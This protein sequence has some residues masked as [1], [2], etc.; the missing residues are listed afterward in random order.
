MNSKATF[1]QAAIIWTCLF[2]PTLAQITSDGTTGSIVNQNNS[3]FQIE[4]GVTRG[5]TLFHSFEKFSIPTNNQAYFTNPSGINLI[6]SRVTGKGISNI[7][8][9]LGVE[10]GADL[11]LMN[12]NGII[13]GPNASLDLNG[14]FLAT[15]GSSF[16]FEDGKTFSATNPTSVPNFKVSVPLGI[17]FGNVAA[18]IK[19]QARSGISYSPY[20]SY[21]ECDCG[22]SINSGNTISFLSGDFTSERGVINAP[23]G[24]IEIGSVDADSF[25]NLNPFTSGW[26]LG[27]SKV[28]SFKDISLS[29]GYIYNSNYSGKAGN[30]IRFYSRKQIIRDKALIK[31]FSY[32]NGI[33]GKVLINAAESVSISSGG[34]IISWS[35]DFLGSDQSIGGDIEINT[36]SLSISN[37]G[38]IF[39]DSVNQSTGGN[40]N[41]Q[42]KDLKLTNGGRIKTIALDSGSA[43]NI[44]IQVSDSTNISGKDGYFDTHFNNKIYVD[45]GISSTS[46][47]VGKTGN[48]SLSTKDIEISNGAGI[49]VL[50]LGNGPTGFLNIKGENLTLNN[51]AYISM[52]VTN[53]KLGNLNIDM[54][55]LL[56]MNNQSKITYEAEGL[57]IGGKASISAPMIVAFPNE[58]SDIILDAPMADTSINAKEVLGFTKNSKPTKMSDIVVNSEDDRELVG[59]YGRTSRLKV[60]EYREA[61]VQPQKIVKGCRPGQALGNGHFAYKGKGGLPPNPYQNRTM[62]AVWQDLR[63]HD[64]ESN[65]VNKYIKLSHQISKAIRD[66]NKHQTPRE[67]VV[68]KNIVAE[69][70]IIE[71]KGWIE[72]KKGQIILTSSPKK[73]VVTANYQPTATC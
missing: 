24:N 33:R 73:N 63:L 48:L 21:F 58:N 35:G 36:G 29:G 44:N 27:Y 55:N 15:T 7:N 42:S 37:L 26:S 57:G 18:E 67:S 52:K 72:D 4:G 16:V 66:E 34:K 6:L 8:G 38:I 3:R 53:N 28:N 32:N 20:K 45:S 2:S 13:F 69:E 41:I 46:Y 10:G 19:V 49:G 61:P 5:N 70:E 1:L 68:E 64:L 59:E 65:S 25:V 56:L 62:P 12:P 9:T 23:N 22:L 50:G 43:G 40:I 11:F 39:T 51:N 54:S 71:A 60:S 17:Q 14:S 47:G 31:T 30:R